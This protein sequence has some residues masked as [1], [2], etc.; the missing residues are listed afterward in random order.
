MNEDDWL[1]PPSPKVIGTCPVCLGE[2][3]EGDMIYRV[4]D[5]MIHTECFYDWVEMTYK[6]QKEVAR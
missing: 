1:S 3:Y 6:D 5:E 4:N 2:V